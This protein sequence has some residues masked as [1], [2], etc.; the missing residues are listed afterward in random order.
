LLLSTSHGTH[1]IDSNM[2]YFIHFNFL[3]FKASSSFSSIQ[4]SNSNTEYVPMGKQPNGNVSGKDRS[5]KINQMT[6]IN[7]I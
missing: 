3:D 1:R 6:S 5:V 2:N 7:N 4:P